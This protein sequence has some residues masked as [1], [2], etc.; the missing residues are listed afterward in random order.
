MEELRMDLGATV[1]SLRP[2][3]SR[4]HRD[5]IPLEKVNFFFRST[6]FSRYGMVSLA[7]ELETTSMEVSSTMGSHS[8]KPSP[9]LI[10]MDSGTDNLRASTVGCST[11]DGSS[12][13]PQ[14]AM[15]RELA[16]NPISRITP[17]SSSAFSLSR[18]SFSEGSG[19][20][21]KPVI[22]R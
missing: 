5:S 2:R 22:L 21:S 11:L 20:L 12:A 16:S 1:I 15:R 4:S 13:F 8:A 6:H 9:S 7:R 19:G 10:G 3:A 14:I 18:P 17:S